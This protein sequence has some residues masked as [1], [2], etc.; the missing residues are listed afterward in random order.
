MIL[1]L[2]G[3]IILLYIT[4]LRISDLLKIT[5]QNM[6]DLLEHGKTLIDL[7]KKDNKKYP[8]IYSKKSCELVRQY[9]QNFS[10][11]ML[12]KKDDGFLFTTQT[13]FDKPI[14]RSSFD[15]EINH[16][17]MKAGD[18]LYKHIRTHSFRASIIKHLLKDT[19]I[20]VVKNIIGHKDI[21]ATLQYKKNHSDLIEI[22]KVLRNLDSQRS[23][24]SIS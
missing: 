11:L 12:G 1:L 18:K 7:K 23:R 17:L 19:A 8:I 4:G 22:E 6:Q 13:R 14:N 10:Q 21:N 9:T 24:V 20:D 16:I 15:T 3:D 5:K 2:L